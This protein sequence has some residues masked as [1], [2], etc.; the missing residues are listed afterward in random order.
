[1]REYTYGELKESRL[2]YDRKTPMFGWIIT[3]LTCMLVVA[4][5]IWA[6]TSAKT[7]VVKATGLVSD[8]KKTNIMNS[9]AG[10]V[11]SIVV[12]EGQ[13][14]ESGDVILTIDSY[15]VRLQIAQ[16]QT[17]VDIYEE[18]VARSMELIHYVENYKID[19]KNTQANPFNGDDSDEIRFY[20]DADTFLMYVEQQ[21]EQALTDGTDFTQE[22]VDN[23]KTP[24]LS[25][26]SAFTYLEQCVSEQAQQE[27]QLKMYKDSLSEYTVRAVGDGVVHLSAGITEG[28]VL[29]AGSLL[30]NI[31]SGKQENIYIDAV[32][33]ATERSKLAVGSEVEIAVSGASQTDFGVLKG[34]IAEIDND[35]TQ[36]EDGQVYYRVK[37]LPEKTELTD[38]KGNCVRLTTGM[39]GECRIKYDETTW[40]KWAIEQIG[41]KFR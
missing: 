23:I 31:V 4:S 30:G 21:K 26:Q 33:S 10:E 5:I 7:Y 9:V 16:L 13:V 12:K 28:T 17:M 36:T 6:A 32:V 40:L 35:S 20:S 8:G 3:V 38:K 27:S 2:L 39:L 14:V 37:I 1:M 19:D 25:Q 24:F 15:Q 29:S 41:V 34:K 22:M 11:E 18:K